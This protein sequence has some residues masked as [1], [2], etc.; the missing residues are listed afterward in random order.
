VRFCSNFSRSSFR[1]CVKSIPSAD[2]RS[3]LCGT[4]TLRP[5][6]VGC[7]RNFSLRFFKLNLRL[8]FTPPPLVA[9]LVL[10]LMSAWSSVTD[11]KPC[12]TSQLCLCLKRTRADLQVWERSL[13]RPT[14]VLQNC[15]LVI[16]MM[17]LLEECRPLSHAEFTLQTL[18]RSAAQEHVTQLSLFW[19][20]RGKIKECKLGNANTK[21][22]HLSATI[23]WRKNQIG[24]LTTEDDDYRG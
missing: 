21:F 11:S 2:S 7:N 18:V 14:V 15:S 19:R 5:R 9:Y 8:P 23:K 16:D 24:A 12:G 1:L 6:C 17:D 3:E 20:Q 22:F 13:Q 4:D 10:Q